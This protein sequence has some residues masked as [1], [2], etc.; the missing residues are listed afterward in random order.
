MHERSCVNRFVSI[1]ISLA[2][3]AE[4]E[5]NEQWGMWRIMRNQTELH[6]MILMIYT[7]QYHKKLFMIDMSI[8]LT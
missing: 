1:A 7:R 3:I 6:S 8:V 4:N 2:I 5:N